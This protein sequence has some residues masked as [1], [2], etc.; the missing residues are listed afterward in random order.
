M[1]GK[2][3]FAKAGKG[4]ADGVHLDST[5][6]RVEVDEASLLKRFVDSCQLT[7]LLLLCAVAATIFFQLPVP[8]FP[9]HRQ[10]LIL[11]DAHDSNIECSSNAD[12]W[13]PTQIIELDVRAAMPLIGS[14]PQ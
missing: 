13:Q 14:F 12:L 2:S 6:S 9:A 7:G 8:R 5:V 11:H 10:D 3:R 4:G 1:K